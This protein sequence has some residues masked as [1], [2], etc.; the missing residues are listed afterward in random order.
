MIEL[1]YRKNDEGAIIMPYIYYLLLL[2]T[3]LLWGGNFV[4]GKSLVDHASPSTLTLLRWLIAVAC[5]IPIVWWK[6]KSLRP[7]KKA[8]VPLVLMGGTGVVLFNLFQFVALDF[9]S[10]TNVGLISTLNMFSIA[11]SS[12]LFLKEKINMFQLIAM[13]VSLA[14]V[15]L[16][17]TN[18]HLET[19]LTFQFNRGDLFMMAA[20]AVWGLYAV[21]SKWAMSYTTP[22]MATMYS[23]IFGVLMLVP[24]HFRDFTIENIDG[25]FVQSILYTGV[26]S[27][28]VC[29]L[30]WNIGVQKL[31]ATTSGIFLNFN[32]VFTAI[33]AFVFLGESM[34]VVQG[35]GSLTVI[36]G[37][38]M[39]TMVKSNPLRLLKR[40]E[41][42]RIPLADSPASLA[43]KKE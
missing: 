7:N 43:L 29:M 26:I 40:F 8:I 5:L 14:G 38:V 35:I 18:G 33:L 21:C 6:E 12:Y 42:K 10:A 19:L 31:G 2:F 28:V 41:W 22:L 4:V 20:V 1:F 25:S 36:L 32:P 13:L 3:S 16:V 15:L 30:L 27:T 23:G 39:F 9:T 24:F 11:L 37:S 17:L 34:T